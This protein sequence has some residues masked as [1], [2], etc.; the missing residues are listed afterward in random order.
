VI[1]PFK[2]CIRESVTTRLFKVNL[3]PISPGRLAA[4]LYYVAKVCMSAANMVKD[5]IER[6][7][8]RSPV[9]CVNEPHKVLFGAKSAIHAKWVDDVVAVRF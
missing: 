6:Y 5:A 1:V 9:A 7:L 4:I 8:Q 3:E 2:A